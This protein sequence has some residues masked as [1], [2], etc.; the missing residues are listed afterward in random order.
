MVKLLDFYASENRNYGSEIPKKSAVLVLYG[1]LY[2]KLYSANKTDDND[3]I[4]P[5]EITAVLATRSL[6]SS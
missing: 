3:D 4:V 2:G 5:R 1:K 6:Y